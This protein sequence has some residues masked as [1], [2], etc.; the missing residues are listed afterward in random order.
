MCVCY[1]HISPLIYFGL[2]C[3]DVSFVWILIIEWNCALHT[4][5]LFNWSYRSV[6]TSLLQVHSGL[7]K[8][9]LF[10]LDLAMPVIG[11]AG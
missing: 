1:D 8:T 3:K 10:W 6:C 9:V 2:Y 5:L 11:Q 4:L 7:G